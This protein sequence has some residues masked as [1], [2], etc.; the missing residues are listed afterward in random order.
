M[1]HEMGSG[2]HLVEN[3]AVPIEDPPPD[4]GG[5][6]RWQQP[7]QQQE[8]AHYSAQGKLLVEEKREREAEAELACNGADGE[9]CGVVGRLGEQRRARHFEV[10]L[11]PAEG[12]LPGEE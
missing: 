8:R 9:E 5:G 11:K 2:Q 10:V 1:W 4:G 6:D 3:A 12:R 7:G